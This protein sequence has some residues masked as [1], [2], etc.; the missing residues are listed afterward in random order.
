ML[1][2]IRRNSFVFFLCLSCQSNLFELTDESSQQ[3]KVFL[4][5]ER[6]LDLP[7]YPYSYKPCPHCNF[8]PISI[9]VPGNHNLTALLN[10]PPFFGG[11]YKIGL[12]FLINFL[13]N[14]SFHFFFLLTNFK[15]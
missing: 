1:L 5:F 2:V 10:S 14:F 3:L 13:P 9:P 6:P 11:P 4:K 7:F 8:L 15:H 12:N